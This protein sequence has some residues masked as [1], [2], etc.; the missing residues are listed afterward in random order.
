MVLVTSKGLIPSSFSFF[1]PFSL[2][3]LSLDGLDGVS[4]KGD[5]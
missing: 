3:H 5:R 4:E 2:T 1:I